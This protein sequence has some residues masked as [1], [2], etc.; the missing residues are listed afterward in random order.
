M[1]VRQVA[2]ID[3]GVDLDNDEQGQPVCLCLGPRQP[4]TS[5]WPKLRHL[6]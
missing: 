1:A 2:T 4:W 6:G 5:L 3:N